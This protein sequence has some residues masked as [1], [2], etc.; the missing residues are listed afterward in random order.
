MG[1]ETGK[2]E[3]MSKYVILWLVILVISIVVEIITMAS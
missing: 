3:A 2:E 1:A